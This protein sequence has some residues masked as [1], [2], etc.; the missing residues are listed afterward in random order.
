MIRLLRLTA[1]R[2]F[3]YSVHRDLG[4]GVRRVIP[5]CA[6]IAICKKFPEDS[7]EYTGFKASHAPWP[8]EHNMSVLLTSSAVSLSQTSHC[9][10]RGGSL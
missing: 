4:K 8:S 9:T 3:T 6:V 10:N 2:Q 1:Y 5:A 7:G